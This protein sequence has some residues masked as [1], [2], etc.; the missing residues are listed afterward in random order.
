[1]YSPIYILTHAD[2]LLSRNESP[3]THYIFLTGIKFCTSIF[4]IGVV[5]SL[6]NTHTIK[7]Y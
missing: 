2:T 6:C 3:D 4:A 5:D 1:M 7:Y